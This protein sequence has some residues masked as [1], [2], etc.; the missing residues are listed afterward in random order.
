MHTPNHVCQGGTAIITKEK[1][2]S[3][4]GLSRP[5][6]E[7]ASMH[8]NGDIYYMQSDSDAQA[9]AGSQSSGCEIEPNVG[10]HTFR[11][12]RKGVFYLPPNNLCRKP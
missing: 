5:G 3:L 4:F 2:K 12:L 1:N 11:H 7:P 6:I 9:Q 8:H 10:Q